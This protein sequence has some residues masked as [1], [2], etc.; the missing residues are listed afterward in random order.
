[1]TRKASSLLAQFLASTL[2]RVVPRYM[3]CEEWSVQYLQAIDLRPLAES[4][5]HNRHAST[6]HVVAGIGHMPIGSVKPIHVGKMIRDLAQK[7][8]QC[9]K[10]ALF[11]CRDFF[12][13][14]IL[15]GI[16]DHNPATPIK[17]PA[18]KIQRRRLTFENWQ[19]IRAWAVEHQ[20]PWVAR[21]LDLALVTGQR[22]SDVVKMRAADV[23]DDYLHIEQFKTG[24]RLAL[25][26]A[27]RLDAIGK[28]IGDVISDC[29]SYA[30]PGETLVRRS[31]GKALCDASLSARF[32]QARE[33]AGLAW[34][35]GTP[36]SLHEC[37][38]LSE[39]LYRAQ[40]IDT[41]TLLGHK[42]QSMTDVYND[43]RGLSA[44]KWTFLEL[45]VGC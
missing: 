24:T 45:A 17:P 9:A 13:E 18:V 8:P 4:T 12:G 37:R 25:P 27:L 42:H 28:T 40:G 43:D 23:W 7:S 19:A 16:I 10:R 30:A 31:G 11:E 41:K 14:A 33:G 1:M 6:K 38:S 20:P 36:P 3:T 35:T 26:L 34:A 29:R 5:L 39:R 15:A 32:E 22:R 2:G 44:G 21:L